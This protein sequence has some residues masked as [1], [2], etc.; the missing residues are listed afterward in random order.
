MRRFTFGLVVAGLLPV[1]AGAAE[2]GGGNL[3]EIN[4]AL[5]IWTLLTFAVMVALLSK[6]AFKP[7]VQALDRRAQT[8]RQ[9]LDDAEQSRREAK[10][11]MDDYQQQLQA[12]RTEANQIL[13][14]ARGLGENVRQDVVKQASTEAAAA[15]KRAQVEIE[16][17][18]EKSLQELRTTVA[19][20]SV[21]IAGKVIGR[22]VNESTH[23][24]LVEDFLRDLGKMKRL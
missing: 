18:K 20:L 5:W 21:Q 10:K 23:R 11:L 9:S 13:E 4:W 24:Q 22:E 19:S 17:E 6:L 16:R 3:L 7:I 14:Q 2:A 12:A 8:I 1:A 15:I